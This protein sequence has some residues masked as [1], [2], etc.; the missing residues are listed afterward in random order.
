[1]S[2]ASNKPLGVSMDI[3]FTVRI[4]MASGT[5]CSIL[6]FWK[7]VRNSSRVQWKSGDQRQTLD[8]HH[9]GKMMDEDKEHDLLWKWCND[10]EFLPGEAVTERTKFVKM[11]TFIEDPRSTDGLRTFANFLSGF[12]KFEEDDLAPTAMYPTPSK[13]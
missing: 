4:K 3:H 10:D 13:G 9:L 12:L 11:Q 2:V 6:Q 1:M 7:T 5:K 8:E